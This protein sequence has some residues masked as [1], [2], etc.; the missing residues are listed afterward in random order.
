MFGEHV[1]RPNT[2][3]HGKWFMGNKKWT[4]GPWFANHCFMGTMYDNYKRGKKER[5]GY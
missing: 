5:K 3:M 2:I 4:R 1:G